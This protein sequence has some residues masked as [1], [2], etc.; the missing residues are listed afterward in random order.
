MYC[1][2]RHG[3][4]YGMAKQK[5]HSKIKMTWQKYF[6]H[7]KILFLGRELRYN[8]EYHWMGLT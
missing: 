4:P 7:A 2:T 5:W 6:G 8:K 1:V 3:L